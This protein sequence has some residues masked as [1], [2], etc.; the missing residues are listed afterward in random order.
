M[1]SESENGMISRLKKTNF[2]ATQ[3]SVSVLEGASPYLSGV[4]VLRGE[5]LVRTSEVFSHHSLFLPDEEEQL[6]VLLTE[7]ED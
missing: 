5:S 2:I 1:D 3:L 6:R 4:R 7:P